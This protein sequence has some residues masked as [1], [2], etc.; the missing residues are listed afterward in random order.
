MTPIITSVET[1]PAIA[2][3]ISNK[4]SFLMVLHCKMQINILLTAYLVH[5]FRNFVPGTG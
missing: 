4:R 2:T 3:I 1:I 5:M